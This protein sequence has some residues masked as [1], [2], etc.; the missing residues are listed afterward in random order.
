[1]PLYFAY[2][3]NMDEAAM[4]ERCPKSRRLARARLARHRFFIM[5]PGYASVARDPARD[6]HG[7]LYD[8]ALSDVPALDRYEELHRGLYR[9]LTQPVL[10]AEGGA[11]Q[12]LVYVGTS[13]AEGRAKPG[14]MEAVI[15]AAEAGGLPEP[16]IAFLRGLAFGEGG[17]PRVGGR[18]AIKRE[19]FGEKVLRT[20][21][22]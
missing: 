5:E 17:S 10:R 20:G 21:F 13:R 3:S 15:I 11:L 18:R 4:R 16:Y 6:V 14:Y 8:L 2:G 19:S 9:K 12:A 7:F 1:M 22:E